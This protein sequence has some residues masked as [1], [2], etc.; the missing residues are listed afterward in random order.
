MGAPALPT[1]LVLAVLARD[2]ASGTVS[3]PTSVAVVVAHVLVPPVSPLVFSSLAAQKKIFFVKELLHACCLSLL[4][5]TRNEAVSAGKQ[6]I[7]SRGLLHQER[8][9]S[10]ELKQIV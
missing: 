2:A 9:G 1:L 10:A 3:R 5:A 8:G 6:S 7:G 4:R